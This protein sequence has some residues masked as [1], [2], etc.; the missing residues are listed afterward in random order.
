MVQIYDFSQR[1]PSTKERFLEE[2]GQ[3]L[4]SGISRELEHQRES[5]G[6]KEDFGIDLSKVR[7]PQTRSAILQMTMQARAQ[8]ANIEKKS[9]LGMAQDEAKFMQRQQ[10]LRQASGQ[11]PE[12]EGMQFGFSPEQFESQIVPQIEQKLG[13]NLTPEQ[14]QSVAKQLQGEISQQSDGMPSRMSG[15]QSSRSNRQEDPFAEAERY[16]AIGEHD[17][18]Q[19][20]S[21]RAE[22][23][24]RQ[25]QKNREFY[26]K[27]S[28][29]VLA[30]ADEEREAVNKKS[31]ALDSLADAIENMPGGFSK[32]YLAEV[33]G[34]E[35][36]RTAKGAQFKTAAKEFL[37]SNLSRAGARPNQWIEQQ[38]GD[39]AAKIGRSKEA[40][41]TFVAASR[42]D[43]DIEKR[44]LD[45][46]G[47]LEE[48][49]LQDLGYVPDSISREV[50]KS[51]RPYAE[52]VQ[53]KLA[54]QLRSIHERDTSPKDLQQLT[55]V[56]TGTPLT[57]RKASAIL[58][59]SPGKTDEE[60][61]ENALKI[62][63]KLGYQI[64]PD[65][66]YEAIGE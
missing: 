9:Q 30:K 10:L 22:S 2:F 64:M 3:G 59:Q 27:R 56:P 1:R 46:L 37:L 36:F 17:L 50:D 23:N 13:F 11:G 45:L 25:A 20:S 49:Y 15:N 28:Q 26:S 7:D 18:S 21:K 33:T 51:L 57:L 53:K 24:I 43:L 6:L 60:R 29:K 48:K 61:Q 38:I 5:R 54:Y 39:M 55:K 31:Y 4:S 35:P 12:S 42:A 52:E 65:E 16:A 14:K 62:A 58:S 32:D 66:F 44:R 40:N 19:I 8:Q 47:D 63:K 34:Y 41:E